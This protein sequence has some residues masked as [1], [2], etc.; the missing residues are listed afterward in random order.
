M[1]DQ[2]GPEPWVERV[3]RQAQEQ[4]KLDVNEGAGKPIPGLSRPYDPAW[5]ARNW[6]EVERSRDRAAE[7]SRS[8]ERA[9]PRILA[10]DSVVE[11]RE[12]LIALNAQIEEHNTENHRSRLPLLDVSRLLAERAVRR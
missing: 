9:L 5:W 8:V 1:V 4:G 10:R 3:I 11:V 12:G 6:I 2:P 7:L